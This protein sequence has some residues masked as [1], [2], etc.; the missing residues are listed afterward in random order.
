MLSLFASAVL[1]YLLGSFPTAYLVVRWKAS[2]DIRKEGSGNVGSLNS[3]LV[4]RSFWVGAAVLLIDLAKGALAVILAKTA[5]NGA[6]DPAVVAGCAAVIGHNYPAWLG[7]RGGRGLA[8]A[9]GVMLALGWPAV[10][11]WLL[12]WAVA[13]APLREVNAA[14]AA[15]SLAILILFLLLPGEWLESIFGGAA[16]IWSVRAFGVILMVIVCIKLIEPVRDFV[17]MKQGHR[18]PQGPEENGRK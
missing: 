18:S 6:F 12:L 8:P 17:K 15:A 14:N 7:F 1:G 5:H 9:A 11:A 10:A 16:S 4:S 2:V 13:Y 3:Y